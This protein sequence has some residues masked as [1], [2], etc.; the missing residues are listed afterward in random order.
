MDTLKKPLW[1]RDFTI[2]TLGTVV[3]M[4]GNAVAGFALGLLVL[5]YTNSVLLY[6]IYM[7]CYA[8]PRIVLPLLAGPLLDRFSRK[9]M[10]Y[11]LDFVSSGLYMIVW[12]ILR[13]GAFGFVPFV[14]LAMA[15]GSIDSVYSVAYESLY[16]MLISEGNYTRAYSVS[17]LIYPLANTVMVPVAAICYE[18]VGL[19]PLFLFNAATFLFAA[20]METRIRAEEKHEEDRKGERFGL[21]AFRA[22]FSAGIRYL[23]REKGL[24]TITAYFFLTTL[25]GGICMPLV[26][27]YFKGLTTS[28]QLFGWE[29]SGVM[30]YTIIMGGG[31]VGRLI[32]GM[33]HYFYR[34]P[35]HKKF[36]IAVFVYITL[37]ALDGSYLYVPFLLMLVFQ[38]LVGILGVTSYNIRISG[39]QHY[40]DD[41][42]RGRFNGVFQMLNMLGGI[43]GTLAGGVLGEYLPMRPVILGAMLLNI[44]FVFAV[45][46]PGRK[47]VMKIYNVQV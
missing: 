11:V 1:T 32:G 30:Q 9:R 47:E 45:M 44:L 23:R 35:T 25:C 34:Y 24:A 19:A 21:A 39:T 38:F 10:I 18:T 22:D 12:L 5:D 20:I 2:I 28:V 13:S 14:L 26:L 36:A 3:S 37:S 31:T 17:S 8:L 33:I 29:L 4:L 42:M 41:A 46:L 15:I 16:P 43:V 6:A 7:T 27:P 40:V